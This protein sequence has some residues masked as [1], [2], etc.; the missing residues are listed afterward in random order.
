[1]LRLK[2]SDKG[3]EEEEGLEPCDKEEPWDWRGGSTKGLDAEKAG[4]RLE[5]DDRANEREAKGATN[6]EGGEARGPLEANVE[7]W[8]DHGKDKRVQD[9]VPE[10]W[11]GVVD[12]MG[13]GEMQ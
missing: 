11:A 4:G 10:P 9:V 5:G 6:G 7:R 8:T 1:M 12:C 13:V 3:A 2:R